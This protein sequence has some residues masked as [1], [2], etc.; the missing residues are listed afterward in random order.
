MGEISGVYRVLLGKPGGK[1]PLGR[2]R[3]RWEDI[4]VYFQEVGCEDMDCVDLA[5]DWDTWWALV[6]SE[7]NFCVP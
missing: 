4:K 7:M 3:L 6:N 5:Q 1:R 2:P